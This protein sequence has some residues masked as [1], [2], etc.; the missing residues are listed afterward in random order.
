MCPTASKN[1]RS[2]EIISLNPSSLP[3]TLELN[4]GENNDYPAPLD[5]LQDDENGY[6]FLVKKMKLFL[7]LEKNE[8]LEL[9]AG[10]SNDYPA[11]LDALQDGKNRYVFLV[12][13]VL[14]ISPV[15]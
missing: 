4:A 9:N 13:K 14:L 3:E 15:R 10:E 8:T 1:S 2:G 7:F 6:V 12:K 11:P 5:T